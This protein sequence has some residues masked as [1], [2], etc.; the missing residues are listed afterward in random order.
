LRFDLL[1]FDLD[2]TLVDS[3]P[4]IAGALNQ[5]LAGAGLRTLSIDV[6]RGLVG[7]GVQ[8]LVEKALVVQRAPATIDAAAL[9]REVVAIYTKKPCVHTRLFPGVDEAL[10]QLRQRGVRLAVLTNK[11]GSVARALLTE[12]RLADR[13]DAV[14][15]DGD[16]HARKPSP[17]A[18]LDVMGR[19]GVPPARTLMVG[20]GLPDLALARAAGCPAAAVTW[21]YSERAALLAEKPEFV[22]DSPAQLVALVGL[23]TSAAAPT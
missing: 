15:G 12:L 4:D 11:V 8:R 7:E 21:G 20:D 9:A 6:V 22:I 14:V 16:G 19:L 3:L 1:L 23:P 2:G 18:A 10:S 13:F 17:A 5:A